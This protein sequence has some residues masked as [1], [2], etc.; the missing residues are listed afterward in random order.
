MRK[1]FQKR[2]VLLWIFLFLYIVYSSIYLKTQKDQPLKNNLSLSNKKSQC[3]ISDKK[4]T[5]CDLLRQQAAHYNTK[6]KYN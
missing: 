4:N 1:T 5:A 3:K 2:I 6:Y